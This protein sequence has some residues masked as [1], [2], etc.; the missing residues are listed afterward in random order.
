[1]V[2]CYGRI[3]TGH[4]FH[5]QLYHYF[6]K[7]NVLIGFPQCAANNLAFLRKHYEGFNTKCS[8]G[9]DIMLA[10]HL[11]KHGRFVYREDIV[12]D[13]SDRRLKASLKRLLWENGVNYL[14]L[15]LRHKP[16]GEISNYR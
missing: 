4:P 2:G 14:S 8:I 13:V 6:V 11:K 7:F 3:N 1:M 16:S 9:E 12:A 10:F 5:D 15:L